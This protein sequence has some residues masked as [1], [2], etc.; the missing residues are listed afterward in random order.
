MNRSVIMK[1]KRFKRDDFE[2]DMNDEFY[3]IAGYTDGGATFGLR[4]EEIIPKELKFR[5]AIKN[6]S[7]EVVELI[8]LAIG[9]IAE[10]LTGQTKVENIRKTL[11]NFFR[12]ENNRVSYQNVW[13]AEVFDEVTGMILTYS[14]AAAS[15]LDKPLL[16]RLRRKTRNQNMFFDQEADVGDLYIDTVSVSPKFQG[17]G[18]GTKLLW[19]AE[20]LALQKGYERISL[21]VAK[22]NRYAKKLYN[23]IGYQEDKE[24]QINGHTYDYMVKRL[25]VH[26]SGE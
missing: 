17:Y 22:N 6:D 15:Q 26:A 9:D 8:H 10:R 18:I 11:S 4:W 13:I 5:Q 20:E 24:I 19:K 12:E 7:K 23:R 25:K 16:E 14:G 3:F 1:K 21:N 2:D